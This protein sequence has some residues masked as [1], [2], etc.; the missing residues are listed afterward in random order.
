MSRS[1]RPSLVVIFF[2]LFAA[3][4]VFSGLLISAQKTEAQLRA[5]HSEIENWYSVSQRESADRGLPANQIDNILRAIQA[6][7]SSVVVADAAVLQV[8]GDSTEKAVIDFVLSDIQDRV[9]LMTAQYTAKQRLYTISLLSCLSA[10][11]ALLALL[12]YW[13]VRVQSGLLSEKRSERNPNPVISLTL[14]GNIVYRNPAVQRFLTAYVQ[15]GCK[16][17]VILPS[18]YRDRLKTL[19]ENKKDRDAWLFA[20]RGR[21]LKL[22]VNLFVEIDRVDIYIDDVTD[23]ELSRARS[24]F[25]FCYDPISYFANRQALFESFEGSDHDDA[26][27]TLLLISTLGFSRIL[28]MF[29][30]PAV[31]HAT[32]WLAAELREACLLGEYVSDTNPLMMRYDTNLFACLYRNELTDQEYQRL[33]KRFEKIMHKPFLLNHQE[34]YFKIQ[35]GAA[36]TA[37]VKGTQ[38]LMQHANLALHSLNQTKEVFCAY[39]ETISARIKREEHLKQ[40]LRQAVGLNQLEVVYQPQQDIFSGEIV[41]FEALLRWHFEGEDIP[42]SI[43]I[44]IA[45]QNGLIEMLGQFVMVEV[46][47]KVSAV[48]HESGKDNLVFSFNVSAAEFERRNYVSEFTK[49][50]EQYRVDP[51][52]LQLEITESI[53]IDNEE[54]AIDRMK[55]LR[56]LG[57]MLAIDDF[58][59][60]YSSFSYLSRFPVDKLK[61]DRAF[62]SNIKNSGRDEAVVAA[63]INVA[64][65]L[66]L[67]VIAE[68]VETKEEL[69]VL[70]R[71]NCDQIQGYLYGRPM[72]ASEMVNFARSAVETL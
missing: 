48:L 27:Y 46:I 72:S 42:P 30:Y 26:P 60:G 24:E 59:T 11:T 55:A 35:V 66:G 65:K 45:E 52:N 39:D 34:F 38:H 13:Q 61:I 15:P 71:L 19:V 25:L 5:V 31:H 33:S 56:A 17:Q 63:M 6:V 36:S 14:A 9:H 44:P 62:V 50:I 22:S 70:K 16:P 51:A 37:S 64:H 43:F 41:G 7:S 1:F 54:S 8:I 49:L 4:L 57:V 18:N 67:V 69:A 58:G 3:S 21:E 53:L 20:L 29:G 2:C 40:G 32:R 28:S 10:L 47:R 23:E 12:I 68:G